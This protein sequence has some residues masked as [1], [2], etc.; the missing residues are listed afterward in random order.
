MSRFNLLSFILGFARNCGFGKIFACRLSGVFSKDFGLRLQ[1]FAF[2]ALV[3]ES[4]FSLQGLACREQKLATFLKSPLPQ[5]HILQQHWVWL[6]SLDR[7][8][9]TQDLI[10]CH[11]ASDYGLGMDALVIGC[12][13]NTNV[14]MV[15]AWRLWLPYALGTRTLLW[16]EHG[17]SGYR[18]HSQHERYYGLGI[19]SQGLCVFQVNS[20]LLPP[21]PPPPSYGNPLVCKH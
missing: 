17:C 20:T 16:F 4:R 6:A 7:A 12:T 2:D 3:S 13:R 10:C 8:L 18:T 5:P 1:T 9:G 19:S 14:I 15:W 11:T 21:S